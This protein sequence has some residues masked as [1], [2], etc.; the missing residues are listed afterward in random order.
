MKTFDNTLLA[1]TA[2]PPSA[3]QM[4]ARAALTLWA[5]LPAALTEAEAKRDDAMAVRLTFLAGM[6][7]DDA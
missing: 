4:A 5:L 3:T 1:A 2:A 6:L 7:N